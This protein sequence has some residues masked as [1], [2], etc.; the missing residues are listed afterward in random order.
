MSPSEKVTKWVWEKLNFGLQL[1][2]S[3][4]EQDVRHGSEAQWNLRW[5]SHTH[6]RTVGTGSSAPDDGGLPYDCW[7]N[8]SWFA[9]WRRALYEPAERAPGGIQKGPP[10]PK[11]RK[12]RVGRRLLGGPPK[13][14]QRSLPCAKRQDC[15]LIAQCTSALHSRILPRSRKCPRL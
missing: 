9:W 1:Q 15:E 10:R 12:G 3:L 8:R 14:R 4:S 6:R 2:S 7:R 11:P 5:R 13:E